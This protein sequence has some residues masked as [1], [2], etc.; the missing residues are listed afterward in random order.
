[1]K[2]MWGGNTKL[3]ELI[4][5]SVLEKIPTKIVLFSKGRAAIA[6]ANPYSILADGMA[7]ICQPSHCVRTPFCC[8]IIPVMSGL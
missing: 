5:R 6:V 2:L 1:M 7:R 8:T 3:A 4:V